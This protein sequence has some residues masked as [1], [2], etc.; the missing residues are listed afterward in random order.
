M[1]NRYLNYIDSKQKAL[2]ILY[3]AL[4]IY[5]TILISNKALLQHL[6]IREPL[7]LLSRAFVRRDREHTN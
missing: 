7:Y 1:S 2:T 5:F 3:F 6:A 4:Y